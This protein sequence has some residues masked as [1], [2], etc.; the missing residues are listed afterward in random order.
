MGKFV[1]RRVVVTGAG[2]GIGFEIARLF[3]EEGG[4]V[5]AADRDTRSV[6]TGSFPIEVDIS[7]PDEID[8]LREHAYELLG[9]VDILCNNAG[10]GST[11]SVLDA[12][13]EEW[14]RVFAVNARG[15]FLCMKS[16]LPGM[17]EQRFGVIV[18]T[19]SV[20]GMIGLRDRASY[21]ASKGAVLT[22]TKQ[23][24]VQWADAGIR[25]NCV[26]PGTVDSPWVEQLLQQAEDPVARRAE[27]TAR[28]PVGR[29]AA[30]TEVA[31]AVLYLASDDAA[32][33]TG[34]ELVIDGGILAG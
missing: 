29:L 6:P 28:Q 1:G 10:I 21:S 16:F 24:A 4:K 23:A 19:A 17:L 14:D 31:K 34:A 26:C 5:V 33:V 8:Q 7:S 30:P 22:L 2:S 18:N 15:T 13:V 32:F 20:A 27:L 25:C 12:T 3:L 11:T 9:G